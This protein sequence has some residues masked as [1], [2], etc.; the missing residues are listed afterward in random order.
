[1][2][3]VVVVVVVEGVGVGVW[4]EATLTVLPPPRHPPPPPPLPFLL[5]QQRLAVAAAAVMVAVAARWVE[6]LLVLLAMLPIAATPSRGVLMQGVEGILLASLP[7]STPLPLPPPPPPITPS[8][9]LASPQCL[10]LPLL[11]LGV[12]GRATVIGSVTWLVVAAAVVMVVVRG[13]AP[14]RRAWVG[15]GSESESVGAGL[16]NNAGGE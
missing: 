1:M 11:L 3:G 13:N 10:L 4:G 5:P 8:L 15:E 16:S 9:S 2:E 12:G 14:V 6:V 7:P